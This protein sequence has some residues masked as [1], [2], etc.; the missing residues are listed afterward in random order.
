[1]GLVITMKEEG[2][3]VT[4]VMADSVEEAIQ[5]LGVDDDIDVYNLDNQ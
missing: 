4:E 5:L 2:Y 3:F 1:M